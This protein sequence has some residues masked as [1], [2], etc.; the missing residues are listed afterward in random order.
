MEDA[1]KDDRL[2][3]MALLQP[4]W[5]E[6]YYKNPPIHPV[7]CLGRVHKEER[8]PD[9]RWNLLLHGLARARV[10]SELTTDRPYRVARVRLM[11]EEE[12]GRRKRRKTARPT[13]P[14][15][16]SLVRGPRG[17][18]GAAGATAARRPHAGGAVRRVRLRPAHRP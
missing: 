14:A 11:Q 3:A 5:D 8:L 12:V 6:D 18:L 7:V 9:G 4:G 13:R 17:R 10:E 1:L 2:I 16:E 15:G